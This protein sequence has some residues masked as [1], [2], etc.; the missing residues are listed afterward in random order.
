MKKFKEKHGPYTCKE[1]LGY[2]VTTEEG[3]KITQEKDLKQKLCTKF[4][5]DVVEM[6]IK[7][8]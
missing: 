8:Y 3:S 1:L 5:K 4:I 7:L 2:D 6:S